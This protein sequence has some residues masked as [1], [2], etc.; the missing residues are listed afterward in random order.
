MTLIQFNIAVKG[1]SDDEVEKFHRLRNKEHPMR[2]YFLT[3]SRKRVESSFDSMRKKFLNSFPLQ[4]AF[5]RFISPP[6]RCRRSRML[7]IK[8]FKISLDISQF[9]I[10]LTSHTSSERKKL[11]HAS[12]A[13]HIV[14]KMLLS[15]QEIAGNILRN[16]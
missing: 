5:E 16:L 1:S 6:C 9:S 2:G 14:E 13:S 12:E 10:S 11:D 15:F 3:R 7:F 8:Y 4:C